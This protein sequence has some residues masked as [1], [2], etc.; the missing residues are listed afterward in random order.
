ME[1]PHSLRSLRRRCRAAVGLDSR[2]RLSYANLAERASP[3]LHKRPRPLSM[4][5]D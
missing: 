3:S 2:G 4:L 1:A 5:Q